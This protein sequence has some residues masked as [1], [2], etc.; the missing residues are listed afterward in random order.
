MENPWTSHLE[1][2]WWL[3]PRGPPILDILGHLHKKTHPN[4]W[5]NGS[6][7]GKKHWLVEAECYHD[8]NG[9]HNQQYDDIHGSVWKWSRIPQW[10]SAWLWSQ[11]YLSR[12]LALVHFWSWCTTLSIINTSETVRSSEFAG[13]FF[14][15]CHVSFM[16]LILVKLSCPGMEYAPPPIAH[17]ILFIYVKHNDMCHWYFEEYL[18]EGRHVWSNQV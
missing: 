3:G 1:N 13:I 6:R 7:I 17:E 12:H 5:S 18:F 11:L 15:S 8:R 10:W 16:L 4:T 9:I 2:G 14:E